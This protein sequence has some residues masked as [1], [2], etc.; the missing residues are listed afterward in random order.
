MKES[1]LCLKLI[2]FNEKALQH[3]GTDP[4]E[5]KNP[6]TCSAASAGIKDFLR[7]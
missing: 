7:L 4:D 6:L 2:P 5:E 1:G 3:M